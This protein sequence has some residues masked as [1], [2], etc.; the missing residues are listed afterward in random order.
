[1]AGVRRTGREGRAVQ[2]CVWVSWLS[3][4]LYLAWMHALVVLHKEATA[5]APCA[6]DA[7]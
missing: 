4:Y 6:S 7:G 3:P 1:M 2:T 5:L